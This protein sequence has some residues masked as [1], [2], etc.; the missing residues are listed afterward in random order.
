LQ[1]AVEAGVYSPAIHQLRF[2]CTT[3]GGSRRGREEVLLTLRMLSINAGS[4][5]AVAARKATAMSAGLHTAAVELM[6][7][8][9]EEQDEEELKVACAQLS[10]LCDGA[11]PAR[12]G[13][14]RAVVRAGGVAC[15]LGALEYAASTSSARGHLLTPGCTGLLRIAEVCEAEVRRPPLLDV[16]ARRGGLG[17]SARWTDGLTRLMA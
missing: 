5:E 15:L 8:A 9:M 6:Q 11:D 4:A 17:G 7:L 16:G 2:E 1:A 3:G 12:E 14:V 13:R 10:W